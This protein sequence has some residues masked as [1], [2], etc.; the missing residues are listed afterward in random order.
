MSEHS[1]IVSDPPH[2]D[3]DFTKAVPCFRL[4]SAEVQMKANY[5]LP[6]I[7]FVGEARAVM[8]PVFATLQ[9]VGLRVVF[10]S[11][12][13]LRSIPAQT[14]ASTLAFS[15][16]GLTVMVDGTVKVLTYDTRIV[17]VLCR[18]HR[19]LHPASRPSRA[20]AMRRLSHTSLTPDAL[21]GRAERS[22]GAIE[23]ADAKADPEYAAF[24]DLYVPDGGGVRRVSL[25]EAQSDLS[26]LADRAGASAPER[27]ATLMAELQ[28]RFP[29]A[30]FDRRLDGMRIRR[31]ILVGEYPHDERRKG[32]SF[33]TRA[34][35][36]LLE[37]ISPDIKRV[38]ATEF[39][40]R[41]VFLTSESRR[42]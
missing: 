5:G 15:D 10:V 41:L 13:V 31:R 24:V 33:A 28:E 11:G 32:F 30:D 18:P 1:L 17:G 19:E 9:E 29:N 16:G 34:L 25:V 6:E 20:T 12:E 22:G 2:G 26:G 38:T 14:V 4:S 21:V 7:W 42:S 40:S 3:I 23:W 37:A 8:E 35:S 39:A 36:Q 27:L